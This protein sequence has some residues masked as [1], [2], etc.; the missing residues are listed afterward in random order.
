MITLAII[1]AAAAVGFGLASWLRLPPIPL[2]IL[3]GI[4]L[5]LTDVLGPQS[6]LQN[7]LLLGLTFL[8]FFVGT[9]LDIS[10]VRGQRRTAVAVGTAHVTMLAGGGFM[11]SAFLGF[12]LLSAV[13]VAVAVTASSTLSVVT[14][15]RQRQQAFEPFARLVIGVLL[16]QDVLVILL[17]PVLTRATD[18]FA[19]IGTGILGTLALIALTGVCIRWVSPWVLLRLSLDE[20]STLLAVLGILFTFVGLAQ[21]M[22]LPMVTG[23]FLAGVAL[24]SF[25]VSGVV[26]GQ[27][28]SLSDFFL[29]I[30]FVTLGASVSLPNLRQLMLEGILLSGVLLLTPPLVML[31]AR[32]AGLTARSSIEAAHLLAQCGEFSLVVA[33]LGVERGHVGENVLAVIVLMVVVTITMMPL[34]T[35]DRVTWQ[36]MRRLPGASRGE[37]QVRPRGHVLLLGC[38]RHMRQL[39]DQLLRHQPQLVVVDEDAGV[40]GSL[41]SRGIA[42]LRGDGADYRV[43]RRA[44]ARDARVIISTMRRLRDHERL[45]RFVSGPR[46]LV[47]VFEPAEARRCESLGAT[48]VVESE[49]AAQEFME[50]FE[51]DSGQ[52]PVVQSSAKDG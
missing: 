44:G 6:T 38:G 18:G 23:A 39:L 5:R 25:P 8:V 13:Y 42:A 28:S 48:V 3:V 51:R 46:V 11:A 14:L 52:P 24:S 30:F 26:R 36:L 31:L 2:L 12:D 1:L 7:S 32:R 29:A 4:L 27:V 50:W 34:L 15:M 16:L 45:L 47:R 35:S 10:R 40:I 43:L 20:E 17:L 41:R 49:A 9:E 22:G 37:P 33:L 19:A 21:G